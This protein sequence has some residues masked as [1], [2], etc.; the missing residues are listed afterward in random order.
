MS[1]V[2]AVF[3]LLL[4]P[5]LITFNQ[6]TSVLTFRNQE[7]Q[8]VVEGKL[9]FESGGTPW[10]IGLPMD[11]VS[12]RLAL[13]DPR[14]ENVQGYVSF[15]QNG[16]TV[17]MLFH[18]RTRQFY[19]GK[20]SFDGS[21]QFQPDSFACRTQAVQ[22][23]RVLS[24]GAGLAD[25]LLND[26]I[27]SAE[28]DSLIHFFGHG[29]ELTSKHKGLFGVKFSGA[30][31]EASEARCGMTAETNYYKTRYVPYYTPI[32]RKRCPSPPTGWM[33]WNV[34]FDQA[35]AKENLDEAKLGKKYLQPFG[36]EFWSIESWQDNSPKLPVSHFYNL[37]LKPY[38]KQFPEGMKKLAQDIRDLGFR[39]GLWIVPY[40]TGNPEFYKEHKDWFLHNAEGKP[41]STWAGVYTLDPTNEEAMKYLRKM[42][43]IYSHDWGYEFFKIDGMS[44]SGPGYSAHFFERPEIRARFKDPSCKDGFEKMANLFREALGLDRVI[45]ACQGHATGPEVAMSDASRTGADIVHPNKPVGWNN[46]TSQAGRTLNQAFTHNIV[47][48]ADPDTLLV[49]TALSLEEARLSTTVVSL[50][51]QLMFSGDKLGELPM[52]RIRLIQK[53][54][55]V[56]DVH[57]MNLYPYFTLLPVWDLKVRRP[58]LDWDVVALFNW[59]EE[60]TEVG[61]TFD[62]IGLCSDSEYALYEYWT[63]S[64]QGLAKKEFKI[65]VP[66]HGVRLLAVH[67][68]QK[69][70]PQFLSSDRHITQGAVDL[71]DLKIEK[72]K[73]VGKVKLVE[74]HPTTLRFLVPSGMNCKS[75]VSDS[76]AKLEKKTEKGGEILAVVLTDSKTEEVPFE[77]TF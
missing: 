40:A 60:D 31:E 70:V 4:G 15:Q 50:P 59:S 61:F 35:G 21:V 47:F 32:D 77:I 52:D 67:K 14:G 17:S 2:A 30:I 43:D 28:K 41:I 38:A 46:L 26:S 18:H 6:D 1:P 55:P 16:G 53:T 23:E 8:I 10:K 73:I 72:N 66:K 24:L 65:P 22:G 42:L 9:G 34:Y 68:L 3:T 36:L 33:S 75:I 19:R 29:L 76:K 49:N 5:W 51:G 20:Y 25:S 64:Y 69:G 71:T 7:Q 48:Y 12:Q 58:Y 27:F 11:N 63:S 57:P 37:N 44:G 74:N 39:P 56:C 45:L 54:L 62:E 13:I